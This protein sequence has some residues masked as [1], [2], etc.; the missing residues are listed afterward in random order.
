MSEVERV[1]TLI[2]KL[3]MGL[4]EDHQ[5]QLLVLSLCTQYHWGQVSVGSKCIHDEHGLALNL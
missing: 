2:E 1:R 4:A 5:M 3:G